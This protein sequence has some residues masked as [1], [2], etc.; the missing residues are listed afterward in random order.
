MDEI[1][2]IGNLAIEYYKLRKEAER[3]K[4]ERGFFKCE[5]SGHTDE[6]GSISLACCGG[7]YYCTAGKE[8]EKAGRPFREKSNQAAAV[9]RKMIHL[10]KNQIRCN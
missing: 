10:I 9:K 3:L 5:C 6:D 1:T 7:E 4:K 8:Y 2:E